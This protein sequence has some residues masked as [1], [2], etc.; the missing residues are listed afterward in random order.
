MAH[1]RIRGKW[2]HLEYS[3]HFE[4]VVKAASPRAAIIGLAK[5]YTNEEHNSGIYWEK[6]APKL[7]KVGLQETEPAFWVGDDQLYSI[8]Y[9]TRVVP[10]EVVCPTCEGTGRTQGFVDVQGQRLVLP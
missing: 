4:E 6:P 7:V 5:E 2:F 9:I 3:H 8:R 1:Y 10:R